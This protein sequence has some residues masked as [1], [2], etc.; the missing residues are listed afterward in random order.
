MRSISVEKVES[1]KVR[2]EG[3]VTL[4]EETQESIRGLKVILK[5]TATQEEYSALVDFSEDLQV[6]TYHLDLKVAGEETFEVSLNLEG[7]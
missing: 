2:V 6:G 4:P 3:T 7:M 5:N 1:A